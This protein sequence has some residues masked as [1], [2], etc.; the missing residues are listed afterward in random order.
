VL[1]CLLLALGIGAQVGKAGARRGWS[2]WRTGWT[3][4]LLTCGAVLVAKVLLWRL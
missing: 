3:G 4:G 1:L 2:L